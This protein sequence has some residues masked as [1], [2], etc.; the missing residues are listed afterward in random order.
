MKVRVETAA[1]LHMGFV[2]LHGGLG[3]RFGSI[4]VG[5]QEPR[6][7][8]EARASAKLTAEGP[9][10]DRAIDFADCF[11]RHHEGQLAGEPS[12]A[13][14]RVIEAI[15]AHVG[16]GSGTQLALAVGI[17]LARLHG[18]EA[19]AV[20]IAHLMGRGRRSSIGIG[21][22][23]GG[24]FLLDGGRP[25]DGNQVAPIIVRRQ[26]PP[27]W[28]FLIATPSVSPGLS[29]DTEDR[30][31]VDLIRPSEEQAGQIARLLVMKMLP[32]LA[33]ND[34]GRFGSALTDIQ[35]LVGDTFAAVQGGRFA[36]DTSG[37]L[38][39]YLLENG[40]CGAGQSSWGPTVYALVSGERMARELEQ[41]LRAFPGG[42][43]M[44]VHVSA[45][46]DRGAVVVQGD[47]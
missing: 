3:R 39:A 40:A 38:I 16:L 10:A 44:A 24:G 1:R 22:F 23:Q 6:L 14:L 34:V 18:I 20:D 8:L 37:R 26:L 21:S 9:S 15:P 32:A 35:R 30:A 19:D 31:F 25:L 27:D 2:D 28:L 46:S 45:A 42:N 33:R 41:K 47:S 36:N 17:A 4:G 7:I 29:G 13:H 43:E 11:Y 5:L 12:G